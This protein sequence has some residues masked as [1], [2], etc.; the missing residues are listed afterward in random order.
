MNN[1]KAAFPDNRGYCLIDGRE[2]T[3]EHNVN[4][5]SLYSSA[6]RVSIFV[7][8]HDATLTF[9]SAEI[10][11]NRKSLLEQVEIIDA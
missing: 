1:L 9:D 4:G 3:Y 11:L 2:F 10:E 6:S 7:T 5:V 8:S